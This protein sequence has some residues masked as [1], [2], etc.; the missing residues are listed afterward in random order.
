MP[1]HAAWHRYHE[2]ERDVRAQTQS[3]PPRP[4]ALFFVSAYAIS[5]GLALALVLLYGGRQLTR[6]PAG[7]I[8]K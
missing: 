3:N 8:S 6:N 2:G 5:W 1:P 7:R 4:L